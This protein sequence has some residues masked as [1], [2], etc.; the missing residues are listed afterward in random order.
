VIEN[1]ESANAVRQ[2][3]MTAR[4]KKAARKLPHWTQFS[5]SKSHHLRRNLSRKK[6]DFLTN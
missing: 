4:N 2:G 6:A 1:K 5:M 3:T